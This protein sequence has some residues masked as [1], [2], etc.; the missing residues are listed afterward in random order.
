[1]LYPQYYCSSQ[2]LNGY[3][4]NH[5]LLIQRNNSSGV[6]NST[7]L[8]AINLIKDQIPSVPHVLSIVPA[9]LLSAIPVLQEISGCSPDC[10]AQALQLKRYYEH[11]SQELS[12]EQHCVR[13]AIAQVSTTPEL[14]DIHKRKICGQAVC[15]PHY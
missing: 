2:F 4:L 6:H 9:A 14:V 15:K 8:Q 10:F 12:S 11:H 1:M 7:C 13:I 3:S 5:H